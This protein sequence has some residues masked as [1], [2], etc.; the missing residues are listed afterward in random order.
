MESNESILDIIKD[1]CKK[2]FHTET[3]S[4]AGRANLLTGLL[5]MFMLI[6]ITSTSWVDKIIECINSEYSSG[7]PWY[8]VAFMFLMVIIYFA[9]CIDKVSKINELTSNNIEE[10]NRN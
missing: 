9:Y 6:V 1:A 7:I 2:C 3:S 10:K 8:G 4:E 5:C